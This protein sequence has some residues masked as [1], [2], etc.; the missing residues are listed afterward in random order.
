MPRNVLPLMLMAVVVIAA[1]LVAALAGSQ[2]MSSDPAQSAQPTAQQPP[3]EQSPR[4]VQRELPEGALAVEQLPPGPPLD[5][6][7]DLAA[8]YVLVATN[9]TPETFRASW[10]RQTELATDSWRSTLEDAPPSEAEIDALREEETSSS[11]QV[12]RLQRDTRVGEPGAR[13]LVEVKETTTALGQRLEGKTVH[14]VTLRRADDG[15]WGVEGYTIV[16][17]AGG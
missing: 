10:E 16:P 11:S 13:V 17:G 1:A 2:A 12:L 5:D 9:W 8:R 3:A 4:T 15:G 6:A 14:E 7:E